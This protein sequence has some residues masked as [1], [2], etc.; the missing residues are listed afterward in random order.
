[1]KSGCDISVLR[2]DYGPERNLSLSKRLLGHKREVAAGG[3]T[4]MDRGSGVGLTETG[5]PVTAKYGSRRLWRYLSC[6]YRV[7]RSRAYQP[8]A[9]TCPIMVGTVAVIL[10][11]Q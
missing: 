6:K 1:M 3:I 9:L 2:T 4:L 11:R 8:Q 10:W 7:C 5:V